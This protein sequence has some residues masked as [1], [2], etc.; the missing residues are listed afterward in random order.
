MFH[1]RH[2]RLARQ[3]CSLLCFSEIRLTFWC[4]LSCVWKDK[5]ERG[6]ITRIWPRR[7]V[8]EQ[9]PAS[10]SSR[11]SKIGIV[12]RFVL[13]SGISSVTAGLVVS[14]FASGRFIFW[15]LLMFREE[16][17]STFFT[18]KIL[19]DVCDWIV[20]HLSLSQDKLFGDILLIN[21]LNGPWYHF[22]VS[23][24]AKSSLP[25]RLMFLCKKR[26]LPTCRNRCSKMSSTLPL[27]LYALL[28]GLRFFVEIY[29]KSSS[30]VLFLDFKI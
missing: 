15:N 30:V 29:E 27:R 12:G 2:A 19:L 23:L 8:N 21:H 16:Y 4:S 26:R 7:S 14:F 10:L 1:S 11:C 3:R 25:N 5:K 6:V 20:S 9:Y 22:I 24:L 17:I 13:V 18:K 28:D